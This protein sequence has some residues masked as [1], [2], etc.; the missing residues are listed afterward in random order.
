VTPRKLATPCGY[1]GCPAL[2]IPGTGRCVDHQRPKPK[3][4]QRPDR[5]H[6]GGGRAWQRT[7][8]RILARDGGRC[9]YCGGVAEV[10]DHILA[11]AFGGGDEDSNL[12][13][14]CK[15]CNERKRG[16]EARLGREVAAVTRGVE[17][18]TTPTA[19]RRI[20]F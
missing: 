9:R 3:A 2:T 13:A 15:A 7:R 19:D 11:R 18:Q 10:V 12:V 8:E 5:P 17:P 4:W 14:A 6:P 20:T 16:T 1:S